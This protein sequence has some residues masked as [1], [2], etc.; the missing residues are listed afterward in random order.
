VLASVLVASV[1]IACSG[2]LTVS[3]KAAGSSGTDD[4]PLVLVRALFFF[5]FCFLLL[6]QRMLVLVLCCSNWF[7]DAGDSCF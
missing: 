3:M 1:A 2:D 5:F 4:R 7:G 6:L